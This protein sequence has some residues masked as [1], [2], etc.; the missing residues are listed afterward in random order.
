MMAKIS[1]FRMSKKVITLNEVQLRKLIKEE[2][3]K[4]V[5]DFALRQTTEKYIEDVRKL[6]FRYVLANKNKNQIEQHQA[7]RAVDQVLEELEVKVND[8]LEEE[9]YQFVRSV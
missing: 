4:G 3:L 1:E 2:Y 5:P 8:L 7:I 6:M 9:L